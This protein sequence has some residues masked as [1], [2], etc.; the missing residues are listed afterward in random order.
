MSTEP[1]V[2][3]KTSMFKGLLGQCYKSRINYKEF[4]KVKKK[5]LAKDKIGQLIYLADSPFSLQMAVQK[6]PAINF[7]FTSEF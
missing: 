5:F 2:N 3:L 7:H 1:S 4:L 6:Y